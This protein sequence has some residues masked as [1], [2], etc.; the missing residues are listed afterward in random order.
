MKHT[1][2]IYT[3]GFSI[4]EVLVVVAIVAVLIML[5]L[6]RFNDQSL[7]AN[8]QAAIASLTDVSQQLERHYAS[9]QTFAGF[10]NANSVSQGGYY[11]ISVRTA[12]AT[13]YAIEATAQGDQQRDSIR[14]FRINHA[15][16]QQHSLS[17]SPNNFIPGWK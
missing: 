2:I 4:I 13:A 3:K 1:R 10:P 16:L 12:T 11:N 17:S 15:G 6:P 8:R 9:N 7:K 14:T 5:I